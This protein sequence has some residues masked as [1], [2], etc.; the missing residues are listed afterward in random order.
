[1]TWLQRYYLRTFVRSSVWIV[2]LGGI[3]LAL[4]LA[5][6]VRGLDAVTGWSLLGYTPNGAR[7]MLGAL[8]ASALSFVVFT[9]S[10]LLVAIQMSSAN[11]S[12]RVIT[13]F[14]NDWPVKIVLGC[15]VFTYSYT[16]A[17]LGRIEETVPQLSML[18]VLLSSL[19]S[20]G[21]FVY[22]IDHS[23]KG[24]R[25]VAVV[26]RVAREGQDAIESVYPKMFTESGDASSGPVDLH[27]GPPSHIITHNRISAVLQAMDIQGLVAAAERDNCVIAL[28]PQVGE[29]V[30][31]G[32]PLFHVFGGHGT[33]D[34]GELRQAVAF[35]H[36]RTMQQDPIYAFRVLVDVAAKALS[37]AIN[38]P[39][40]AV[41]S[42]HQIHRLLRIVGARDLSTGK[43]RD[44]A[45]RLRLIFR[46]PDWE[47]FVRLAVTEI[48][49]YGAGSIQV[50]RRLRAMLESLIEILPPSRTPVLREE[51]SLVQRSV[52]RGFQD[53]EDQV[54]A[55]T[56]DSQGVGGA[57]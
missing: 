17:V 37:P 41:L 34:E 32:E 52:Q 11:L 48:R 30:A 45:G 28:V 51:L 5:P 27:L 55:E 8:V 47:D 12:P 18:V 16:A 54:F 2:P 44:R 40:T 50:P 24:M 21:A 9:F 22:L 31:G 19:V 38:D 20:I 4:F 14:L 56:A 6:A 26:E 36:A 3:L 49:L 1:M 42:I 29:F 46:M 13:S 7:T 23:A 25:P 15:F 39:T 53:R 43:V 10:I 57:R 33:L 35:G